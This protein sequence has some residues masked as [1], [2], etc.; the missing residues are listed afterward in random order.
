MDRRVACTAG[1]LALLLF[2]AAGTQ[3]QR[4]GSSTS[5][6]SG[7]GTSSIMVR[8]SGDDGQPLEEAAEVK[9]YPGGGS[10][11]QFL[12]TA[13]GGRAEFN[14]LA[15]GDYYVEVSAPGYKPSQEESVNV[16]GRGVIYN[17]DVHLERE[18]SSDKSPSISGPILAPKAQKE[19]DEGVASLK[20]GK[21]VDAQ[22][23]LEATLKL[24]PANP[25]ANF[26]LGY[27]F[28]QENDLVQSNTYLMKSY[29][30]DPGQAKT[31]IALGQLRFEQNDYAKAIES[32]KAA[33]AMD[34]SQSFAHW[35]LADSYLRQRQFDDAVKEAALAVQTGKGASNGALVIQGEALAE[36]GRKDEAVQTLE[37]FLK[38]EPNNSSV[39]RAQAM[40]VKLQGDSTPTAQA[41]PAGNSTAAP[42]GASAPPHLAPLAAKRLQLFEDFPVR[43]GHVAVRKWF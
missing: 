33:V 7:A 26:L 27:I 16:E 22:Q 15:Q 21:F 39:P 8:V 5:S 18:P 23:H 20:A 43:I 28:L 32:L 3:A 25:N 1:V 34:P 13:D 11:A 24:A 38:D 12:M 17:V 37:L 19:E 10:G 9:L 42:P 4:T 41:A 36:L 6:T 29:S 14:Q 35:I 2:T 40:L 31:L 30:L